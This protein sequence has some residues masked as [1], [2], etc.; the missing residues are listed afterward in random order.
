VTPGDAATVSGY[1]F[2]PPARTSA[3]AW[4]SYFLKFSR[5]SDATFLAFSLI[6]RGLSRPLWTGRAGPFTPPRVASRGEGS[7][8]HESNATHFYSFGPPAR[9]SAD[10]W[11]SYFLKF[12]RN[13]DATFLAFSS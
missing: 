2:G 10:A 9:T 7:L 1:S 12:S 6:H 4:A 8:G 3:D 5:N 11:A 13:S